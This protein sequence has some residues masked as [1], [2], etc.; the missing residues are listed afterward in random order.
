MWEINTMMDV[1]SDCFRNLNK[2]GEISQ[3]ELQSAFIFYAQE[4]TYALMAL[5]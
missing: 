3:I 2:T 4:K 1:L 5:G